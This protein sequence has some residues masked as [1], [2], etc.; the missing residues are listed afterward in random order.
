MSY[1]FSEGAFS[2]YSEVHEGF[3]RLY[4]VHTLSGVIVDETILYR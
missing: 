2:Y 1:Y 4:K 3:V